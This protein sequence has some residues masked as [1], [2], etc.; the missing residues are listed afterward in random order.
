MLSRA[1]E[2]LSGLIA[3]RFGLRPAARG[4]GSAIGPAAEQRRRELGLG[5]LEAYAARAAADPEEL[6]ALAALLSNGWTWF[7]RDR[8]QLIELIHLLSAR[9][10]AEPAAIW[11][12]G[13]STG[14][15]AY[16]IAM[17]ARECGLDVRI[18]ATDL[19]RAR[20]EIA[21]RGVYGEA[22][23][24]A[25]TRAER[26]LWLEPVAPGAW[27]VREDL[28]RVVRVRRHNLMDAP[29]ALARFDAVVC[30]NVLIHATDEGAAQMAKGLTRSLAR[31]GE[32]VLGA[33]DLLPI[34]DPLPSRGD[35][36]PPRGATAAPLP[37]S[38]RPPAPIARG[39]S[40]PVEV[41]DAT[42][43]IT[44]GNLF[45]EARA[46][47]RAEAAY[48]RAE[49]LDP[50]SAELHVAWGVLHRKRGQPEEAV[51]ALRR[52]VFLDETMWPAWALLAGSLARLGAEAQSAGA[53][54]EA[55]RARRDRPELRW[56]SRLDRLLPLEDLRLAGGQGG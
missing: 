56:R 12:A 30:R 47:D 53:L 39:P 11:V 2:R 20:L 26:D 3:S 51:A 21:A 5:T 52:A 19:D 50:C 41:V 25:V 48:R 38:S 10:S 43:L 27:R 33:S 9:R 42:A 18:D 29:P 34:G 13:C 36:A 4:H 40:R 1:L 55:Q 23:L 49:A 45:V 46:F 15:E 22:T 44:M 8:E 6:W 7:F 16:G 28:R 14:E 24:R 17:L 32:L 35:A 31:G 54:A 37:T